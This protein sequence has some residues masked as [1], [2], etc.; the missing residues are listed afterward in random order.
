MDESLF[1]DLHVVDAL[2]KFIALSKR[3]RNKVRE[4]Q[5]TGKFGM[6]VF[7]KDRFLRLISRYVPMI[8]GME[9]LVLSQNKIVDE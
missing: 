4:M 8:R 2:F 7:L 6:T 5:F 9:S 1:L 3:Y